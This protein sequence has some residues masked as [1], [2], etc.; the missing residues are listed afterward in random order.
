MVGTELAITLLLA[1]ERKTM[2]EVAARWTGVG[3]L[4]SVLFRSE[5]RERHEYGY[6]IG[7]RRLLYH[8]QFPRKTWGLMMDPVTVLFMAV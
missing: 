8:D 4:H 6:I 3:R 2:E 5:P 1:R 7:I